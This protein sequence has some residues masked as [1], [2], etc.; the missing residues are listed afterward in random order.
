[1]KRALRAVAQ[2]WTGWSRC[3]WGKQLE[4]TLAKSAEVR[5]PVPVEVCRK[6]SAKIGLEEYHDQRARR[7]EAPKT[8]VEVSRTLD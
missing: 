7:M 1:M 5:L 8:S 3:G 6:Q 4:G 2:R